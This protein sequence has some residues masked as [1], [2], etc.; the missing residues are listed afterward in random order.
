METYGKV[1]VEFKAFLTLKQNGMGL[2]GQLLDPATFSHRK[3]AP[4]PN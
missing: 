3:R 2:N 1:K 4:V